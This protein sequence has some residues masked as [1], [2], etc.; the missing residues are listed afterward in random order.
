MGILSDSFNQLRDIAERS[1]RLM[2]E[3]LTAGTIQLLTQITEIG[4]I[5][6]KNF[7]GSQ[8]VLTQKK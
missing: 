5:Y 7:S 8:P 3:L 2:P 4:E 1:R 6:L